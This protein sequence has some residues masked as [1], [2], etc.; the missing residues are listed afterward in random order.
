MSVCL[1][2]GEGD[3]VG[4]RRE[5]KRLCSRVCEAPARWAYT[6]VLYVHLCLFLRPLC[7]LNFQ[8][9]IET[10][11]LGKDIIGIII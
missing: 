6:C 3:R 5:L 10:L 7:A 9:I 1:K 11:K 2:A 8:T 4:V